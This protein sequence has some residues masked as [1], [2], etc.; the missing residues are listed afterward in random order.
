MTVPDLT[1]LVACAIRESLHYFPL[2]HVAREDTMT[3]PSRPT[4][5]PPATPSPQPGPT[6]QPG[7]RPQPGPTPPSG[8]RT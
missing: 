8:P 1:S 3:I 4:T 7:P 5:P 2:H 6:P